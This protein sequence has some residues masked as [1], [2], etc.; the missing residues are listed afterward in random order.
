MA[1]KNPRAHDDPRR[2]PGGIGPNEER[3]VPAPM[4]DKWPV[5]IGSNLSMQY[6][7]SVSRLALS[8]FRSQF[9]DVLDEMLD[10]EPHGFSVLQKRIF[11]TANGT[12]QFIPAD[13]S[14]KAIELSNMVSSQVEQIPEK[15]QRMA[16]LLW[17]IYYGISASEIIWIK[18]GETW[19]IKELAFIHPRRLS[20]PDSA[21]W[22]L[23]VWDQG[24]A[25]TSSQQGTISGIRINDYPNK[26]IVHAP[27]LRGNYPTREGTGRILLTYFAIKRLILRVGAQDYERFVRPWVVA[28]YRTSDDQAPDK[29]RTAGDEDVLAADRA[30]KTLGAGALA[31]VT[32]PDSVRL[33]V[34]KAV[35]T[36]NQHD[37]LDYLDSAIS[38]VALGQTFTTQHG[39]YGS[40]AAAEVGKHDA[41]GL[42]RYDAGCLQDSLRE[43][44]AKP[45]IALNAPGFEHLT[46]RVVIHVAEAPDPIRVMELAR[47]G[48]EVDMPI[49]ADKLAK[50]IS[51]DLVRPGDETSRR[52]KP[53]RPVE[54]E[55]RYTPGSKEDLEEWKDDQKPPTEV[56]NNFETP[57]VHGPEA[58]D[59][60]GPIIDPNDE[61]LGALGHRGVENANS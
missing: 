32:L 42:S 22:D 36:L 24:A 35:S 54:P 23:Y 27:S 40:R 49:D 18:E 43:M 25:I 61:D 30:V 57:S 34:L 56:I 47:M 59:S 16:S 8:G 15:T 51:L 53:V 52:L 55:V 50:R 58:V 13:D 44:L 37:F 10:H 48:A 14:E 9:V 1:K 17:A 5:I 33:E 38:K 26:F 11:V 2:T 7:S 3:L 46:P 20:Y 60:H 28:Y 21:S 45:I 29:P 39:K 41:L 4:I 19:R 12:L 6:L 31:G